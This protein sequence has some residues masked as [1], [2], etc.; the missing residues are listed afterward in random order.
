MK[1]FTTALL[2]ASGTLLSPHLAFAAIAPLLDQGPTFYFLGGAGNA[3]FDTKAK[4]VAPSGSSVASE[5]NDSQSSYKIAAGKIISNGAFE[6]GYTDFG[7]STNTG[8][9]ALT[10]FSFG[11]LILAPIGNSPFDIILRSDAYLLKHTYRGNDETTIP[12]FGL[13][14]GTRLNWANGFFVQGQYD[15]LYY[16]DTIE[17]AAGGEIKTLIQ[18]PS[19]QVGVAL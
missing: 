3:A 10:G 15:V 9:T 14:I 1:K 17:G 16:Q 12:G 5:N 2:V 8:G 7:D 4:G 13:G 11:V 19:L 18:H 6:V